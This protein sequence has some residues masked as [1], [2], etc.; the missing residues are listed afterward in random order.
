MYLTT[1][2]DVATDLLSSCHSSTDTRFYF[3]FFTLAAV[4]WLKN[5]QASDRNIN[6]L[7][8]EVASRS[9]VLGMICK[10]SVG[11]RGELYFMPSGR[12]ASRRVNGLPTRVSR[13]SHVQACY[14]LQGCRRQHNPDFMN[15]PVESNIYLTFD[16]LVFLLDLNIS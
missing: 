16:K 14:V 3:N 12:L 1:Y 9:V 10:W 2:S 8:D 4:K 6:V 13:C 15:E 5:A 7:E 11:C